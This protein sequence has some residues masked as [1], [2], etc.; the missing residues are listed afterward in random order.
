LPKLGPIHIRILAIASST[1][2]ALLLVAIAWYYR[3]DLFQNIYDPGQPFQTYTPPPTPNYKQAG[4]WLI[5]PSPGSSSTE[6]QGQGDVFVVGPT[7]YLGGNHWNAPI[8]DIRVQRNFERVVLPNYVLPYAMAG[9]V[10]SPVYRQASL[11]SFLTNRE[12]ARAAQEFAYRDVKRA[13]SIFLQESPPERPIVLVGH[14]QGGLHA[15]RLLEEFKSETFIKKLAAAYIIDH[16]LMTETIETKYPEIQLCA[17]VKDSR[18]IVAFSAFMPQEAVRAEMY[19]G[20]TMVWDQGEL[21]SVNGRPLVCVNPLLWNSSTDFAPA[22]LH[23]GGVAAEGLDVETIPAPS[24]KQTGAQCVGGILEID[25]PKQSSLR[26][27]SRFGGKFRTPESNL[28]YEDLRVDA[29]RR[30]QNLI[31]LNELP[32][33]AP[34]M[35]FETIEVKDSPVTLPKKPIKN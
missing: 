28:F 34:M 21:K 24:P 11:Y 29:A 3:D 5:R 2:L 8:D 33:L 10:Y 25:N 20:K 4:A 7:I 27:P 6:T 12:D 18:C 26:R 35:D 16:P 19:T 31:D 9:R 17:D 14:G 22:R 23:L 13:F 1:F 30:V 15:Q 32:R